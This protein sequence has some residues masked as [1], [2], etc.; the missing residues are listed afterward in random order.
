MSLLRFGRR[1]TRTL[2]AV[3]VRGIGIFGN[4]LAASRRES[5]A[6]F[7]L[8]CPPGSFALDWSKAKHAGYRTVRACL[9][10]TDRDGNTKRGA[11][12]S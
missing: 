11:I 8:G 12:Q 3:S 9:Q 2:Y 4:T 10:I 5:I 6:L 7:Q 1:K